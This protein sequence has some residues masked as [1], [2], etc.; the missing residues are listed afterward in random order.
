LQR[1]TVE[2]TL[3]FLREKG[4]ERRWKKK[5]KNEKSRILYLEYKSGKKGEGS[6]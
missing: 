2:K 4:K 6:M 1:Y 5:R 3:I